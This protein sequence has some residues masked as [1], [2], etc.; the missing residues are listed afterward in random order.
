MRIAVIV[1]IAALMTVALV[2]EVSA[3]RQPSGAPSID[4]GAPSNRGTLGPTRP[5]SGPPRVNITPQ[6]GGPGPYFQPSERPFQ[7]SEARRWQQR[8]NRY[9]GGIPSD[10]NVPDV[11]RRFGFPREPQE[12][13]FVHPQRFPIIQCFGTR[14]QRVFP[15]IR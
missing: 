3:Q 7:G 2:A 1:A 10:R 12:R 4:L 15:P 14:C 13:I 8:L 9:W 5:F 6:R 11:E